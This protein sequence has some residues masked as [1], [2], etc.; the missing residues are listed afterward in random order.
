MTK[1]NIKKNLEEENKENEEYLL[2][3][4]EKE[5]VVRIFED[6][7]FEYLVTEMIKELKK[8][9]YQGAGKMILDAIYDNILDVSN[10][11]E[12]GAIYLALGIEGEEM[13]KD[14]DNEDDRDENEEKIN[15]NR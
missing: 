13:W 9:G 1:E 2:S 5:I 14:L 4:E 8:H 15:G 3:K 12:D 6:I 7:N 10:I 11:E